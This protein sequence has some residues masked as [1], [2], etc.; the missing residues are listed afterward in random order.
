MV[1]PLRFG[2]NSQTAESNSFQNKEGMNESSAIQES[3]LK[4]FDAMVELLR[5]NNIEVTVFD[6]ISSDTPDSIFPNNWIS[7]HQEAVVLYP[8][9]AENRRTERRNDIIESLNRSKK[10]IDLSIQESEQ[11]YLEGTGSIVF[12]YE[13]RIAYANISPRTNKILLEDLCRQLNYTAITFKAVDQQ[14]ADIYHTNVLMCIGSTFCVICPDCM[15]DKTERTHILESLEKNG[16]EI[17]P[18]TYAQLNSFAGNMYQ[19]LNSKGESC[20]VMSKQAFN[21]LNSDQLTALK[22]H[23]ILLTPELFT[24]EKFGGGSAR[25]MMADVR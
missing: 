3:A 11:I 1:R 19:L 2:F 17:I 25:C 8:M 7:F 13:N 15:P 5:A 6:D 20:I 9:M 16:H 24:I 10:T 12:D 23:G 21:S 4:E 22:K 18:I 14:G